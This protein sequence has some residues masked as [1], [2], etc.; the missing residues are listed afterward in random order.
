MLLVEQGLKHL[1][2]VMGQ[3]FFSSCT[4]DPVNYTN[5]R[6]QFLNWFTFCDGRFADL[7]K[8][9][10]QLGT[11]TKISTLEF[12]CRSWQQQSCTQSCHRNCRDLRYK[13]FERMV[14]NKIALQYGIA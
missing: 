3:S 7:I 8:D 12:Q 2:L 14:I 11:M 13:L 9:V 5:W 10:E 6:E 4:D 1:A